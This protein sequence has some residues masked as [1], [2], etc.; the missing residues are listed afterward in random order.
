MGADVMLPILQSYLS[1]PPPTNQHGRIAAEGLA[2][3]DASWIQKLATDKKH[4]GLA[5]ADLAGLDRDRD[6]EADCLR[7]RN[8]NKARITVRLKMVQAPWKRLFQAAIV[9]RDDDTLAKLFDLLRHIPTCFPIRTFQV[10][11]ANEI[12]R[13]SNK[14]GGEISATLRGWIHE[15]NEFLTAATNCEPTPPQDFSRP[16][17]TDCDCRFC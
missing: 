9:I 8:W 4:A 16:N 13:F 17:Q 11:A 14:R 10:A 12:D 15:L 1:S 2:D 7:R 6:S 5:T 3:R